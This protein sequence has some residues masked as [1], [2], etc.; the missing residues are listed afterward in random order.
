MYGSVYTTLG[1][2]YISVFTWLL[3]LGAWGLGLE[4]DLLSKYGAQTCR[5]LT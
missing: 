3:V 4:Q 2:V 5:Y 1:S